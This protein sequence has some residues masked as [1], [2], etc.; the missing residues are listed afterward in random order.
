MSTA[1]PACA[2]SLSNASPRRVPFTVSDLAP[3]QPWRPNS[4]SISPPQADSTPTCDRP[5]LSQSN[6]APIVTTTE[7]PT[8]IRRAGSSRSAL[9]PR[10]RA[11]QACERCR[12]ARTKCSGKNPCERCTDKGFKCEF[13]SQTRLLSDAVQAQRAERMETMASTARS[14]ARRFQEERSERPHTVST[15]N[16]SSSSVNPAH[17]M[18][19]VVAIPQDPS[20]DIRRQVSMPLRG[21]MR[22][23]SATLPLHARGRL[24]YPPSSIRRDHIVHP[25]VAR[26]RSVD[27]SSSRRESIRAAPHPESGLHYFPV[28]RDST[29]QGWREFASQDRPRTGSSDASTSSGSDRLVATGFTY[30]APGP[31]PHGA[32]EV[33]ASLVLAV[34]HRAER[35]ISL[36]VYRT[37]HEPHYEGFSS[38]P[39]SQAVVGHRH[40]ILPRAP[41]S[42]LAAEDTDRILARG[43]P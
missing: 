17:P 30:A 43:S 15:G 2:R 10:I 11:N 12:K 25:A 1:P 42:P 13:A 9:A 33:Q 4:G 5:V 37:R 26:E 38:H 28:S 31:L 27:S 24:P 41:F 7:I 18:L 14:E 20:S 3:P 22:D 39:S 40:G 35:G 21:R 23:R 8:H 34:Q 32:S 16:S 19:S 36:D 6:S 29:F